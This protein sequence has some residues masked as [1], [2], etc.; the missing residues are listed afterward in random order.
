M[1]KKDKFALDK[2]AWCNLNQPDCQEEEADIV[3]FGIPY[4]K[5]VSY[6]G[7]AA[8]G[9]DCLRQNA[10]TSTPYTER[11]QSIEAL[12]VHDAGNFVEKT[13][14]KCLQK[15]KIMWQSWLAKESDSP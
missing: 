7:G 9:P 4:D 15:L 13:E 3:I 14:M 12:R 8:E 11:L 10:F 6:R 5:G 2:E 1:L